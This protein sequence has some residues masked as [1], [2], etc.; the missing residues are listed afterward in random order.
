MHF[1]LKVISCGELLNESGLDGAV[2]E[3]LSVE[4]LGLVAT[5]V[6]SVSCHRELYQ[7]R[8]TLCLLTHSLPVALSCRR[9]LLLRL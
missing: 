1:N 8:L 2:S 4:V 7:L 3:V 6:A 9:D 5:S